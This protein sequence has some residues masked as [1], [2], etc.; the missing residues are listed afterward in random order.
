MADD[1]L[2]KQL[3]GHPRRQRVNYE[4]LG[5]PTPQSQG[6]S[7]QALPLPDLHPQTLFSVEMSKHLEERAG[8]WWREEAHTEAAWLE[9]PGCRSQIPPTSPL[10]YRYRYLS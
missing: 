5:K 4:V 10:G 7:A 1:T 2:R 8:N 3:A 9:V 6:H